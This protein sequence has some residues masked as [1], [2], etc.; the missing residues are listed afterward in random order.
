MASTSEMKQRLM[1]YLRELHLP[2]FRE[3]FE[4]LA[5]CAVQ[6]SFSY[7][8]YLVE[9]AEQECHM[10]AHEPDRALA[11]GLGLAGWRRAWLGLT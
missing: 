6:E 11:A 8:Q 10:P 7:E 4:A 3:E 2:T 9:L 1:E 5:Q